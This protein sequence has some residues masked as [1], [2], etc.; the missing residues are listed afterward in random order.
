MLD[1]I[2]ITRSSELFKDAVGV[3]YTRN[4]D[5]DSVIAHLVYISFCCIGLTSEIIF[6]TLLQFVDCI[7][8]LS[9]GSLPLDLVGDRCTTSKVKT[10][11]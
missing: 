8:D 10:E 1:E 6:D 11:L 2:Q 4:L 3:L 7:V 9:L 5:C